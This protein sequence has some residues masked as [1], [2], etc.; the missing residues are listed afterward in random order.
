MPIFLVVGSVLL[1]GVV[2]F[3]QWELR[4]LRIGHVHVVTD[5]VGMGVV[6]IKPPITFHSSPD[7]WKD[8]FSLPSIRIYWHDPSGFF[9]FPWW[10]VFLAWSCSV[11][12]ARYF[13]RP[14]RAASAFP[15]ETAKPAETV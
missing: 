2:I 8:Y 3:S 14:N 7:A 6:W 9:F 12:L 5:K 1:V 11:V 10:L 13:T 4:V 15:V